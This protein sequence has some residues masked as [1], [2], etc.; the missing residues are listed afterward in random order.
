MREKIYISLPIS[1]R[2]KEAR[3]KADS[4]K[5]SLSRLGYEVVNPFDVYAGEN[6]DYMDYLASDLIALSTCDRIFMCRG[7]QTSKGCRLEKSFAE[8]YGKKVLFETVM[9]P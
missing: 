9:L 7:W 2:E 8:I 6:P 4:I 5:S 3:Q 1:G